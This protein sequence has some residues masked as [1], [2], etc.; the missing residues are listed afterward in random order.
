MRQRRGRPVHRLGH[1]P[2]QV[3]HGL[4]GGILSSAPPPDTLFVALGAAGAVTDRIKLGTGIC[5][6]LIYDARRKALRAMPETE[7]AARCRPRRGPTGGQSAVERVRRCE[8]S[9]TVRSHRLGER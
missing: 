9:R 2:G 1:E 5:T 7:R 6:A 4:P 3:E 8:D